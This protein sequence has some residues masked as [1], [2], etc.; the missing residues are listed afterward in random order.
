M[1]LNLLLIAVGL[2]ICFGGIYLR[3]VC[4]ACLGLIWGALCSFAVV[5]I[6]VG[7]WGIDEESFYIVAVCA[8]VFAIVSCIHDK[9]CAAINSFL[10]IFFFVAILLLVSDSVE[11]TALFLIAGVVALI[12]SLI[13]IR[14]YDYSFILTTAFSGAFIASIGLCGIVYDA[15]VSDALMELLFGDEATGIVVMGTLILGVLGTIVQWRRLKGRASK[16]TEA[17]KDTPKAISLV[18]SI[19]DIIDRAAEK[20]PLVRE[21]KSNWGLILVP[22]IVTIVW[23]QWG[24]QLLWKIFPSMYDYGMIRETLWHY[25]PTIISTIL[26]A[27]ELA[28]FIVSIKTRSKGFCVVWMIPNMLLALIYLGE[29][30]DFL[31]NY[32]GPAWVFDLAGAALCFVPFA[33]WWIIRKLEKAF[34]IFADNKAISYVL[35]GICAFLVQ[36]IVGEVIF[37]IEIRLIAFGP[38]YTPPFVSFLLILLEVAVM[39]IIVQAMYKHSAVEKQVDVDVISAE[40]INQ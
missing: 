5:L 25:M 28:T 14:I 32:Q 34:A 3:K 39:A 24:T 11:G 29:V 1:G 19:A 6:T 12:F 7:L 35:C 20:Y 38:T 37:F 13:S 26:S 27:W 36:W 30:F 17:E 16:N 23:S 2:T 15:E 22:W 18:K 33:S 31:S 4:S 8:V 40:E 10:S 9:L 21:I